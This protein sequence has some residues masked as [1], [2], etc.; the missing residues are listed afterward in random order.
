ML[1]QQPPRS[2]LKL[3]KNT[4][5]CIGMLAEC[6]LFCVM[7]GGIIYKVKFFLR[8]AEEQILAAKFAC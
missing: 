3:L 2:M 5:L 4:T 6:K 7:Y 1:Y 8:F